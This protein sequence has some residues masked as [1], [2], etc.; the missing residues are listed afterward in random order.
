MLEKHSLSIE[1]MILS[2]PIQ[3][4]PKK[5]KSTYFWRIVLKMGKYLETA[6]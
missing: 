3:N 2:V 6:K 1:N 5:I 4:L